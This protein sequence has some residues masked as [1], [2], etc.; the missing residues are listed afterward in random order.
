MKMII[1]E[2]EYAN[3]RRMSSLKLK[4]LDSNGKLI[5]N[6]FIM[7]GNGT[8]KTTSMTLIKGLLDGTAA[9]WPSETVKSFQPS[10]KSIERGEFSLTAKFD[11]ALYKYFLRL[12]YA[13][14]VAKIESTALPKGRE[15]RRRFPGSLGDLFTA[16][17]VRRFVF[18]GEQAQKSMDTE[19]S[20]AEEAI[21]YLYRLDEL[22]NIL[23]S[24]QQILSQI[25]NAEGKA[26]TDL[27]VKKLRT[28]KNALE[29][30]LEGLRKRQSALTQKITL[31][32]TE[33][34]RLE[35]RRNEMDKKFEQLSTEKAAVKVR[36]ESNRGTINTTIAQIVSLI[37][38]P[39]LLNREICARMF[40]LGQSMTKLKLPK[41]ISKDFFTELSSAPV[42]VCGRTIGES[43]K[44]AI[45]SNSEEYLGSDQ[46]AVLNAIKSNLANCEYDEALR[47][48]FRTLENLREEENRLS[49]QYQH[50]EERLI[51]AG[52]DGAR[53]LQSKID[54][55]NRD[56][57]GLESD[58][59]TLQSKDD[60]DENLTEENN[61]HKAE[62][63]IKGYEQKIASA[64]RT[65]AALHKKDIVEKLIAEI[66]KQ[67]SDSLKDEIVKKTNEKLKNVITDDIIEIESID[68]YIKLKD[69]NGASEGQ[70][71]SIA[72][73]FLGTLFEKSE[74][75]FPFI[76]DSP[77]GKMDFAK[78]RA[79]A[80]VIPALFNQL[81]AF[82]TSA[83]VE[84]FADRFYANPDCQY[85]TIIASDGHVALHEGQRYFDSYQR[86]HK[87]EE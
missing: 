37:K 54:S 20:E 63:A 9:D 55:L 6:S 3:I 4:F 52:G 74:L 16:E 10:D 11:E 58:K 36:Q 1:T 51:K 85:M 62:L 21:T 79:V 8:G 2:I 44:S 17:F 33:K 87:G 53:A 34:A 81:I 48:A 45:L 72:Y 69:K 46:Q 31:A 60:S 7:T 61:I 47:R 86:E 38:S 82:V 75:E 39:Y 26:G 14:G 41:T 65:N 71:L 28:Q 59:R 77:A 12:D 15:P 27:S 13:N 73:C 78:R 23:A 43:E 66:K 50:I 22:D 80:D 35:T 64:T 84:Q 19:S 32:E 83:E 76:I 30:R 29:T 25:Q 40:N 70:T 67:A 56:L 24:N 18:D 42:C 57:G 5:K 68:S 49:N